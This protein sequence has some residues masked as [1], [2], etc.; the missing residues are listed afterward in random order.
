MIDNTF[1]LSYNEHAQEMKLNQSLP[2][3]HG[4]MEKFM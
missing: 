3:V 2:A 4:Q 1:P